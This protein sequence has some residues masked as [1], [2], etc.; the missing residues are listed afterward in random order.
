MEKLSKLAIDT[1]LAQ[2]GRLFD[3]PVAETPEEA[4]EF[5]EDCLAQV[6][7]SM[8]DVRDYLDEAGMDVTDLDDEALLDQSE[9]F[10]LPDGTFLI[11]EG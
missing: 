6:V 2:Q 3:E 10:S 9:V 11:V 5:L 1:F 8:K 4:E 7:P